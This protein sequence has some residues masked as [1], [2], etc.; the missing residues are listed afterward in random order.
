[1]IPLKKGCIGLRLLSLLPVLS[2]AVHPRTDYR[3]Q[4]AEEYGRP[5]APHL[6]SIDPLVR[7][8]HDK[9]IDNEQK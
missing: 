1:M 6:K 5:C 2:P 4:E 8:A 9:G 3:N 7:Y